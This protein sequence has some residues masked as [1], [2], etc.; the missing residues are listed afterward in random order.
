[1]D[2]IHKGLL[3]RLTKHGS[4]IKLALSDLIDNI[5]VKYY[6]SSSK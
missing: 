5:E 2:G 4:S 3:L 6:H 1:M